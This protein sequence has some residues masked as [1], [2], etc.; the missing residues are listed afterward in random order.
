MTAVIVECGGGGTEL[1]LVSSLHWVREA[2]G[3]IGAGEAKA[4]WADYF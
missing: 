4:M 2:C 3:S 1:F